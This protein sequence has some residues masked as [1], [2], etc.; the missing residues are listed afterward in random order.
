MSTTSRFGIKFIGYIA[1]I[2]ALKNGCEVDYATMDFVSGGVI[3]KATGGFVSVTN[4]AD[5]ELFV[6]SLPKRVNELQELLTANMSADNNHVIA[7]ACGQNSVHIY[8]TADPNQV[9]QELVE[10]CSEIDE[11]LRQVE[12]IGSQIERRPYVEYLDEIEA[13]GNCRVEVHGF[14]LFE[15]GRLSFYPDGRTGLVRRQSENTFLIIDLPDV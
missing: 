1:D 9:I 10:R 15:N 8:S 11:V 12:D 7:L 5:L 2:I 6:A 14:G 4:R 3:L 13:T